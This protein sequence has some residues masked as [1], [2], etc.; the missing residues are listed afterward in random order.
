M[1]GK[2]CELYQKG[3]CP[4]CEEYPHFGCEHLQ[5]AY[6]AGKNEVHGK[7]AG[8]RLLEFDNYYGQ[9]IYAVWNMENAT[10]DDA[11]RAILMYPDDSDNRILFVDCKTWKLIFGQPKD[12]P[13]T[14]NA[15]ESG[16]YQNIKIA[17]KVFFYNGKSRA[18]EPGTIIDLTRPCDKCPEGK[19]VVQ[20]FDTEDDILTLP[21]NAVGQRLFGT[22]NLTR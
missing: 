21:F 9:S 17:E 8:I 19:I 2:N 1:A 13:E 12:K 14:D 20:P 5:K 4:D 15:E 16:M 6:N 7:L 3:I 22:Q 11:R 10:E 18:L